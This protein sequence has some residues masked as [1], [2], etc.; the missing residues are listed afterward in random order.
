MC[1]DM[2]NLEEQRERRK[3]SDTLTYRSGEEEE[4]FWKKEDQKVA[5]CEGRRRP[6]AY[7]CE[8]KGKISKGAVDIRVEC[9]E[10]SNNKKIRRMTEI[11]LCLSTTRGEET[12]GKGIAMIMGDE[13]K[14]MR[15]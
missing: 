11:K 9:S 4:L 15:T 5:L 2:I 6:G 13:K 7:D 10:M 1:L 12:G 3:G 8:V 14:E